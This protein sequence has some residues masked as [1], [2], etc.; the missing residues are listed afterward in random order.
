MTHHHFNIILDDQSDNKYK[1][2]QFQNL[3]VQQEKIKT[4]LNTSIDLKC[5]IG[6]K[7]NLSLY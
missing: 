5:L 4:Q 7:V 3:K 2:M 1:L 6:M